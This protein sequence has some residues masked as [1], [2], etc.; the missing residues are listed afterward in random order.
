MNSEQIIF[1]GFDEALPFTMKEVIEQTEAK[2]LKRSIFSTSQNRIINYYFATIEAR[3]ASVRRWRKH[4]IEVIGHKEKPIMSI[5]DA[6]RE[7][8]DYYST[9]VTTLQTED[10]DMSQRYDRMP[11]W[12]IKRQREIELEVNRL[13]AIQK[14]F[15]DHINRDDDCRTIKS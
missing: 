14:I 1:E 8:I 10:Q 13:Q 11:E 6:I 12:G 2:D 15:T 4:G 7:T 5:E 3:D 9:R